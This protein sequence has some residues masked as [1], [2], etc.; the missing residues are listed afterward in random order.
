MKVAHINF[1]DTNGG[2]A[3]ATGRIHNSLLKEKI[4]SNKSYYP[5]SKKIYK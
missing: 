2:A 5:N 4:D 1:S 3:I